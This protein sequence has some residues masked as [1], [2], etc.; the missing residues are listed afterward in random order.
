MQNREIKDLLLLASPHFEDT[1]KVRGGAYYRENKVSIIQ[2]SP[3]QLHAMVMGS[4]HYEIELAWQDSNFI[5]ASCTCPY[6]MDIGGC[7]HLWAT[8]LKAA[9]T[10]AKFACID[11]P[12]KRLVF[13]FNEEVPF[14]D[15]DD[16][17]EEDWED[18]FVEPEQ[19]EP[20]WPPVNVEEVILQR[21]ID[22]VMAGNGFYRTILKTERPP[23]ALQTRIYAAIEQIQNES[24]W[25]Y[26]LQ[27]VGN[28]KSTDTPNPT[29]F[30]R[31]RRIWYVL[32]E[33][34]L[35]RHDPTSLTVFLYR[36]EMRKNET[37]SNFSPCTVKI[38]DL[39]GYD[40]SDRPI[41]EMM[42]PFAMDSSGYNY[43]SS[44]FPENV[45]LSIAKI[46]KS[47]FEIFFAKVSGEGK[48]RLLDNNG[49]IPAT[50]NSAF[51]IFVEISFL[52]RP[53]SA[54]QMMIIFKR[55]Q[56][57]GPVIKHIARICD[58][59]YIFDGVL[60]RVKDRKI[61]NA[62]RLAK[63][64]QHGMNILPQEFFSFYMQASAL[65]GINT[66][67]LPDKIKIKDEAM[68]LNAKL[69]LIS[70]GPNPEYMQGHLELKY[71]EITYS[72]PLG[73]SPEIST[74][75]IIG[76]FPDGENV[77]AMKRMHR[78]RPRENMI[79]N[80]F[81]AISELQ[82]ISSESSFRIPKMSL[83]PLA[84]GLSSLDVPIYIEDKRVH[85][86]KTFGMSI[87]SG[88]DWFDLSAKMT[89][90]DQTFNMP[91]LLQAIADRKGMIE[92]GKLSLGI[93]PNDYL[94]RFEK[95]AAL[96][97]ELVDGHVRFKASQGILLDYL[98]AE[99]GGMKLDRK[100]TK[101]RAELAN[102]NG[103]SPMNPPKSFKGKL[104]DY[105]K[106]GLA[107]LDFLQ[108][109]SLGGCLADD[110]GLGKTIQV[111]ALLALKKENSSGK[112]PPSLIVAPKTVV[113]NW[114]AEA[115]K[116]TPTLKVLVY[117]EGERKKTWDELR[118][119]DLI[120]TSYH[121][122]RR[123]IV[124]LKDIVFDDIILDEAQSIKNST[125]QITKAVRLLKCNHRLALSGTPVENHIGELFSIFDFL[126][127]GLFSHSFSK[128]YSHAEDS[129]LSQILNALRPLILRRKKSEVLKDLPEKE[130]HTLYVDL[131]PGQKKTYEE[132]KTYYHTLLSSKIEQDGM[133]KNQMN[134]LEALLRLRQSACHPALL[135]DHKVGVSQE[136]GKLDVL[137][138]KLEILLEE[139]HK[140]L[141]FSQFT[142]LLQIVAQGLDQRKIRY[143]YLDGQSTK[144]QE[145]VDNFQSSE[146]PTVF[147]ISLKA[148]GLGLNLTAADYC[149]IL[150]PWWNP[151][152]E[153]QAIDRAHRI[154][155][156]RKV[157]AYRLISKNTVEEKILDLQSKKRDLANAIMCSD[158][159]FL[160]KM[161]R[162]DFQYLFS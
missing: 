110:M 23:V 16:D 135:K 78:D 141:V 48:L 56:C 91:E 8:I 53:D 92:I 98:L 105:Q 20:P 15:D 41:L 118:K 76:V 24:T 57:N 10:E 117:Q 88:I 65:F 127:P 143:E 64:H 13:E 11:H 26:V 18:D 83:F 49:L 120:L 67:S 106:V 85:A 107:W 42:I 38:E 63:D 121:I 34:P 111:L 51:P 43:R 129:D 5:K 132:L 55:D 144:R 44:M 133:G 160:R 7:K 36:E 32:K 112:R 39:D 147:L 54:Y 9:R 89:F 116:F 73:I 122:V 27:N 108:R 21:A 99:M 161:T 58:D 62:L 61:L 17:W 2:D 104:R 131:P 52:E 139:G 114:S 60:T 156:T 3:T 137:F 69:V 40:P 28:Q 6:F 119:Y 101:W 145:S 47:Y 72:A 126:N 86:A 113:C 84:Q 29:I 162:E 82:W 154:G 125:A 77:Q 68:P 157:T 146:G 31:P 151:A 128:N 50:L 100:F 33:G 80:A 96:N 90:G 1:I 124:F 25:Q 158:H 66:I 159:S 142:S 4:K 22:R 95:L 152:A 97:P 136:S 134:I 37:W 148:G 149:F 81:L 102:L 103:I 71:G 35:S 87:S 19:K 79:A 14:G 155:Q 46:P 74:Q 45:R 123:D 153:A 30:K 70:K 75:E 59:I 109:M 138:E 150:D 94:K 93:L 12:I 140:A 130:E 115:S